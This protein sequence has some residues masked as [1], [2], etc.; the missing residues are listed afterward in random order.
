MTA[1]GQTFLLPVVLA[2]KLPYAIILGND[3]PILLDLLQQTENGD[4][5]TINLVTTKEVKNAGMPHWQK[6]QWFQSQRHL[7][8]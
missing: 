3:L 7:I 5:I 8:L 6:L 2:P 1:G 4:P